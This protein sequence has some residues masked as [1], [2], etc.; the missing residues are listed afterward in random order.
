[1]KYEVFISSNQREFEKERQIIK[2][3]FEEDYFLKSFFNPFLFEFSPASGLSPE[4]TFFEKVRKSDVYIGLIGSDYGT[5]KENGLS[6]TEE[7]YDAFHISNKNSFFYLKNTPTRDEKSEKFILKIQ[8]DNK[9]VFFDDTEELIEAIK[10]SL[11]EFL[12]SQRKD[13]DDF[14]K[15]LVL[16]SSID[17]VDDEAYNLFFSLL[18]EDDS[19]NKLRGNDDKTHVLKL[20]GAGE[21]VNGE[22][23]LN[24]AGVLFF[25]LNITKFI[26]H[27]IKMVRF[28]G[29]TKFDAIDRV[30]SSSSFLIFLDE[31]ENFFKKN[32]RSGFYIEGTKRVNIDEYPLKAIREAIIN[33]LAH[34]N[35]D[36]SSS[37]IEFFIFD[38]RIEVMSP[39]KLKY[40]LTIEDIKKDDSIAHR[41]ALICDIFYK[42]NYMEHIGRGI[43]QM[44]DEMLKLGL[45]EPIFSE[46]NDS[47]K[48]VFKGNGGEIIP[49]ENS[50]NVLNLSDLGLN[51][52]QFDILTEIVNNNVSMTYD[53]HIKMFNTSKPT[54]ERDFR[55]LVELNLVKK[56]IVNRKA[57]FSS[58]DY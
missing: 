40:P 39:G 26:S 58:P 57:Q 53:D 33:A 7:E 55:K 6:A 30:D 32:T 27:E 8:P 1:M 49:R 5:V 20:I 31:F 52:R 14:D 35:Y 36:I 54:A 18:K 42:T 38:D 12:N 13:N 45:E 25:S 4:T 3:H 15:K 48:V 50:E 9:Y 44:T 47:F 17:D 22:F 51:Q 34:R 24:N 56:T 46:G 41:N 10:N 37:F 21:D 2:K 29:V 19:F 16:E 43:S 11:V 23:H 28:N